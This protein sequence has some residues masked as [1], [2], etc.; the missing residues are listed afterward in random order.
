MKT[1]PNNENAYTIYWRLTLETRQRERPQ[2]P[3]S[4]H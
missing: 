4:Q 1:L 3:E 2:Y